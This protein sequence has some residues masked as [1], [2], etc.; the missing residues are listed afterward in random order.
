MTCAHVHTRIQIPHAQAPAAPPTIL[1][2]IILSLSRRPS[3]LRLSVPGPHRHAPQHMLT[4][5]IQSRALKPQ[6]SNIQY[7]RYARQDYFTMHTLYLFRSSIMMHD[8][9]TH[10]SP[11]PTTPRS[12]TPYA[13]YTPPP[14]PVLAFVHQRISLATTVRSTCLTRRPRT[15]AVSPTTASSRNSQV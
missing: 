14:T 13:P 7:S 4:F 5:N 12:P 3:K 6:Y 11:P 1:S 10:P 8:A 2:A 9:H 15:P